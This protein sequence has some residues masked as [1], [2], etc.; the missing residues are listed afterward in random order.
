MVERA[1][2]FAIAVGVTVLDVW[3]TLHFG[4]VIWRVWSGISWI[5]TA[6][7]VIAA[8]WAFSLGD[9]WASVCRGLWQSMPERPLGLSPSVAPK[10]SDGMG[11]G[12][13]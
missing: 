10:F 1:K 8:L 13:V 5:R 12:D 3:V 2:R 7:L 9:I 11:V 4:V 6:L